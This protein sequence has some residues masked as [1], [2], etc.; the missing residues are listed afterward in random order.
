MAHVMQIENAIDRRT[1][2]R[3]RRVAVERRSEDRLNQMKNE[4]RSDLPRRDLDI[5]RSMID[6]E[7]WWSRQQLF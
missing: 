6:G 7:L 1:G 4:C 2:N 5:D 3:D